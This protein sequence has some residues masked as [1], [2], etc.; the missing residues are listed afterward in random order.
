LAVTAKP[1][2]L[3]AWPARRAS[4][5]APLIERAEGRIQHRRRGRIQ[6][7]DLD[8][9]R[10]TVAS[11]DVDESLPRYYRIEAAAPKRRIKMVKIH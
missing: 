10:W 6:D 1:G 3:A 8:L 2:S 5:F 11:G 4:I 9:P 7:Q